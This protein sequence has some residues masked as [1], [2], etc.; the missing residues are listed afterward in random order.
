MIN[1]GK[2]VKRG[3]SK[4]YTDL[5][6]FVPDGYRYTWAFRSPGGLVIDVEKIKK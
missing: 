4:Y 6:S 2:V 5:Q 1:D 3:E